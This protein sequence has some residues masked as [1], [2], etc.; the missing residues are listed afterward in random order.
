MLEKRAMLTALTTADHVGEGTAALGTDAWPGFF[1]E[2][3][4]SGSLVQI[5]VMPHAE[6]DSATQTPVFPASGSPGGFS[7]PVLAGAADSAPIPNSSGVYFLSTFQLG[8]RSLSTVGNG[9]SLPGHRDIVA[10]AGT[11]AVHDGNHL[12]LGARESATPFSV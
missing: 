10:D 11:P 3:A 1:D 7:F 4:R 6:G 5:V 8:G 9:A 2:H 12:A